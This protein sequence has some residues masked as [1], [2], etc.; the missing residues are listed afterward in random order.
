MRTSSATLAL[1]AALA[2]P[3]SKV[4]AL[5]SGLQAHGTVPADTRVVL[6]RRRKHWVSRSRR[7]GGRPWHA[8]PDSTH[9]RGDFCPGTT[10]THEKHSK[11]CSACKLFNKAE[12]QFCQGRITTY[13]TVCQPIGA[14]DN[15]S[16]RPP[17]STQ[18]H[19]PHPIR[20][21][22]VGLCVAILLPHTAMLHSH[23]VHNR[24][25]GQRCGQQTTAI[26]ALRLRHR[27]NCA[28]DAL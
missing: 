25:I 13:R 1:C 21:I 12:T 28:L 24:G 3:A 14:A 2:V 19:P 23:A 8:V 18:P 4:W 27:Y 22:D 10:C 17:M 9:A 7:V 15:L 5:H 11:Y 6:H 16:R 20:T 26:D